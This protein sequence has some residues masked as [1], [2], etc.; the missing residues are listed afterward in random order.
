MTLLPQYPSPLYWHTIRLAATLDAADA[1]CR[2]VLT[3]AMRSLLLPG[4]AFEEASWP[5]ASRTTCPPRAG[6]G[7]GSAA[8][9]HRSE[10]PGTHGAWAGTGATAECR[11]R[12][13][14]APM[15]AVGQARLREWQVI[16]SLKKL[17]ANLLD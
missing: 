1:G 12:T 5:L 10:L 16:P 14:A 9:R 2:D 15:S 17:V 13:A 3:Q 8:G 11:L 6:L 4:A 7:A